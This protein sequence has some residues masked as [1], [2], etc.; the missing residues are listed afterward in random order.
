MVRR[1]SRAVFASFYV[2]PGGVVDAGDSH[3]HHRS[4]GLTET[5]AN[6]LLGVEQGGLDYYSAAIREAFEE[7]AVLFARGA[8]TEWAFSGTTMNNN[9]IESYRAR[10]NSGDISWTDFIDQHDF[11]PAY[12]SLQ[13]IA[14]WQTPGSEKKRF[15]TRFFL[16]VMPDGQSAIHDDGELT[17]SCWMTADDVLESGKRGEMKLMYPTFSTLRDIATFETVNEVVLWAKR[18]GQSGEARS[19]RTFADME[20]AYK[21]LG[22]ELSQFSTNIDQ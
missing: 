18:S 8:D 3:V 7:A 2:F 11:R 6:D 17:D 9:E 19:L 5:Q 13:Y 16:A 21:I 20:E 22:T 10:L 14:Y 12:D 15:S 1:H 4:T